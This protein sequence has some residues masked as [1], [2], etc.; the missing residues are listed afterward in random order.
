M[1][2]QHPKA[3]KSH[4]FLKYLHLSFLTNISQEP[5]CHF[6]PMLYSKPSSIKNCWL[7]WNKLFRA[8]CR[9]DHFKIERNCCAGA[10]VLYSI[11]YSGCK[12][13][14][15]VICLSLVNVSS[16]VIAYNFSVCMVQWSQCW[17]M[18]RNVSEHTISCH[19]LWKGMDS[20]ALL[21]P[22]NT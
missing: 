14:V 4:F 13:L 7:T 9:H 11:C 6:E 18:W 10:W 5:W 3:M 19:L 21:V 2:L 1:L 8:L 20:F 12:P 22:G 16:L 15:F 17:Q